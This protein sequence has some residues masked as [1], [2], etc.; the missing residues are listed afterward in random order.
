MVRRSWRWNSW[1]GNR[2][3]RGAAP[4]A[5]PIRERL[6]LFRVV[7]AAVRFAHANLV[8]H[9]DLKPANI[10]VTADGRPILLDFGIAKLLDPDLSGSAPTRGD[11]RLLTPEY[12]AP[13]QLRGEPTTVAT[14]VWALRGAPVRT[15]GRAPAVRH[16]WPVDPG[17]RADGVPRAAASAQRGRGPA[18]VR[19]TSRGS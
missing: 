4:G 8:V 16:Q 3:L 13:E 11:D 18:V 6:A 12:A 17:D 10:L 2:S 9:R 15:P 1:T 14:D 7:C 5:L 19:R